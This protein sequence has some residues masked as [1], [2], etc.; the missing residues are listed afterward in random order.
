MAEMT[1]NEII[2][3]A[4]RRDLA[5]MEGALRAFPDGDRERARQLQRAWDSLWEQLHHH[6]ETEDAYIWPYVRSLGVLP[7]GLVD[8][9]EAEH[10]AMAAAMG[11]ATAAVRALVDDPRAAVA[12]RAADRVADAARVTD[13]HLVHEERDV[14]PTIVEREDT[15]EWKAVEKQLR[16]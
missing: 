8:T 14:M 6:H 5:R 4:V 1:M 9:M 12:A 2:H 16:K 10:I 7:L 3:A 11:E 15:P 13:A